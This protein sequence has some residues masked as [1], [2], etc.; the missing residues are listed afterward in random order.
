M[1][2]T[3]DAIYYFD[4]FGLMSGIFGWFI[5][6]D[7]SGVGQSLERAGFTFLSW[8]MLIVGTLSVLLILSI[9]ILFRRVV[10]LSSSLK[11]PAVPV[12][13]GEELP[14]PAST[15]RW[16]HV[17]ELLASQN[18]SDWRLAVL[19]ADIILDEIV[20]R[21]GYQG[22]SLGDKLKNIEKSD[23]LSLDDAWEAHKIR[24]VIA[25]RGSDYVL[26][27]REARRVIELFAR[28][29]QEFGYI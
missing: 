4:I 15:E 29:F 18:P 3:Q 8:Y 6:G 12:T 19:E 7:V 13:A 27:Q 9:I 25:H 5:G 21:M 24:N 23:F 11:S 22:Q 2:I 26:T 17:L 20:S 28:V 14:V 16:D 1:E 10:A